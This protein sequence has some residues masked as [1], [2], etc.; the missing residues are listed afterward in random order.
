MIR[1]K[2]SKTFLSGPLAGLTVPAWYSVPDAYAEEHA[3]RLRCFTE[4][5]PGKEVITGNLFAVSDVELEDV[6][7]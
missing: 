1:I 5:H 7:Q 6:C 3:H 4:A 2:Y